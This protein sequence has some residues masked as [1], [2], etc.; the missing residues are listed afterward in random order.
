MFRP[1]FG[2]VAFEL[3]HLVS[4]ERLAEEVQNGQAESD[5]DLRAAAG[6]GFVEKSARSLTV[7][8]VLSH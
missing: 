4:E 5:D 2:A 1:P 6:G 3:S 8:F 7:V